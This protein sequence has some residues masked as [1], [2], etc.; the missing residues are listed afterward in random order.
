MR[1]HVVTELDTPEIIAADHGFRHWKTIYYAKDNG[2]LQGAQGPLDDVKPGTEIVIP[3]GEPYEVEASRSHRFTTFVHKWPPVFVDAHMHIQSG[4]CTPLPAIYRL[5]ADRVGALGIVGA[6]R[7]SRGFINTLGK[8]AT[9]IGDFSR[10]ST[11]EIARRT[12]QENDGISSVLAQ[13]PLSLRLAGESSLLGISIVLTMD[14]D[15]CQVDG[16]DGEPVYQYSKEHGWHY[17]KRSSGAQ[18]KEERRRIPLGSKES[19]ALSAEIKADLKEALGE[20]ERAAQ[21]LE[22]ELDELTLEGPPGEAEERLAA[23]RAEAAELGGE[24]AAISTAKRHPDATRAL[25]ETWNQQRRRTERAAAEHPMRLLPMYH[26]EPRRYTAARGGE[27]PSKPFERIAT[28]EQPGIYVGFKMYTSQGYMPADPHPNIAGVLG[29]FFSACA[30][31]GIPIMTHCSTSGFYTHER[32]MYLDYWMSRSGSSGG[33]ARAELERYKGEKDGDLRFFKEKYLHPEA[34]RDVLKNNSSLRLCLAHFASDDDMWDSFDPGELDKP[35]LDE[36]EV[37]LVRSLVRRI[38]LWKD[39]ATSDDVVRDGDHQVATLEAKLRRRLEGF[40][41]KARPSI[42]GDRIVYAKNWV[43][44]IVSLCTDYPNVYT[45][46]SYLIINPEKTGLL[47]KLAGLLSARPGMMNKIM[48]GTDWYLN[49][50]DVKTYAQWFKDTIAGLEK[51][52][53]DIGTDDNLFYRFAII[54]PMRFYRLVDIGK[55][56]KKGLETEIRAQGDLDQGKALQELRRRY[57][58]LMRLYRS[59]DEMAQD[60]AKDKREPLRFGSTP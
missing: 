43:R 53:D 17:Y 6:M 20:R 45:D 11:D 1:T 23:L 16:Y 18:P 57:R 41:D 25:F 2:A 29:S 15:Y 27:D 47:Q 37:A 48:F 50:G 31:R 21:A 55:Q 33:P 32:R 19:S 13:S 60:V 10:L 34:W 8:V 26:F 36:D 42:D 51:I 30:S 46:L 58:T 54:N 7:A 22:A 56:L 39:N 40:G 9:R 59:L 4:N 44:S 28:P 49:T 12:I 35:E 14:M 24:L 52:R 38:D 5:L 3:D